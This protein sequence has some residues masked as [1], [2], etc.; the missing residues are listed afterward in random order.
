MKKDNQ[1]LIII[2]STRDKEV[3]TELIFPYALNSKLNGWWQQ[4]ILVVWGPSDRTLVENP[5]I[6][7]NIEE[8]I[9]A[10]IK[11]EACRACA[12][13][14]QVSEKLKKLGIDVKYMGLPTTEYLKS[15]AHIL[16]F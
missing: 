8:L 5:E 16:T 13:N 12:D 7:D 3:F 11:I 4:V 14:Y 15:G 6:K 10:G 1:D 2:W 9:A